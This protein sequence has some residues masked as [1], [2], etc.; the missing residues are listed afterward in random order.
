M[1]LWYAVLILFMLGVNSLYNFAIIVSIH[2][3]STYLIEFEK[4]KTDLKYSFSIYLQEFNT[5]I[6][7][8]LEDMDLIFDS[9]FSA[10]ISLTILRIASDYQ[11]P[12]LCWWDCPLSQNDILFR[13]YANCDEISKKLNS[14]IEFLNWTNSAVFYDDSLC[15]NNMLQNLKYKEKIYA[16]SNM[17]THTSSI[18]SRFVKT[19]GIKTWIL[20]TEADSSAEIQSELIANNMMR[21]GVGILAGPYSSPGVNYDG[22]LKLSYKGQE[23][24]DSKSQLIFQTLKSLLNNVN[25]VMEK[26]KIHDIYSALVSIFHLHIPSDELALFNIQN[27]TIIQIQETKINTTTVYDINAIKWIGG[28]NNPPS[29]SKTKINFSLSAGITNNSITAQ[30]G[31]QIMMNGVYIGAED[32]NN[33]TNRLPGFEFRFQD[34]PCYTSSAKIDTS[35]YDNYSDNFGL[36]HISPHS[37]AYSILLYNYLTQFDLNLFGTSDGLIMEDKNDYPRYISTGI[38]YKYEVNALLQVIKL[39]GFNSIAVVRSNSSSAIEWSNWA[40]EDAKNYKISILNNIS[41]NILNISASGSI[42]NGDSIIENIV[43][44]LSRIVIAAVPE[45]TLL[46]MFSK[47]IDLGLEAG[48][49]YTATKSLKIEI[50]TNI[51]NPNFNKTKD[52]ISGT[53]IIGSA[54]FQGEVG[55]RT[56]KTFMNRFQSYTRRTCDYYDAFMLGAN[57]IEILINS[58]KDYEK[59]TNIMREAR[60]VKF[61]G[62]NG[63]IKVIDYTNLRESEMYIMNQIMYKNN[64]YIIPEVAYYY[65][66]GSTVFQIVEELVWTPSGLP[67]SIRINNWP[68]PFKPSHLKIFNE[69]RTIVWIICSIISL[70]T[71][72]NTIFIWKKFWTN[73]I[74][75]LTEKQEI[76][77][78]DSVLLSTVLIELFQVASMGPDIENL[79]G[80][81]KS[82]TSSVSYNID[83]FVVLTNGIFWYVLLSMMLCSAYWVLLCIVWLFNLHKRFYNFFIFRFLGWSITNIMPIQGNLMFIPIISTLLDVFLC[84]KSLSDSFSDSVLDKDCFQKCWNSKHLSYAIPSG[85]FIFMYQPL[86]VYFRPI[87]QEYLPLLHIKTH[88]KFLM[89]KSVYQILLI[90]LNKTLKRYDDYV[91]SIVFAILIFIYVLVLQYVKAFNYDRLNMWQRIGNIA[92]LWLALICIGLKL[93]TEK[94]YVWIIILLIGLA[95]LIIIGFL[96]QKKKYPSLLYRVEQKSIE[97]IIR[98]MIGSEESKDV[99]KSISYAIDENEIDSNNRFIS[100]SH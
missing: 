37:E 36:F 61:Q 98:W 65:P 34:I 99:F 27:S 76:S 26:N 39:M 25:Q 77:F 40:I 11:I 22:I 29:N 15:S 1:R 73:D 46:E 50:I 100:G 18:I 49:I 10:A 38:P 3:P 97:K 54:F 90:L 59:S 31:N 84:D 96:L 58:G 70:F 23:Y 60:K 24:S 4:L 14:V 62:C 94:V 42:I 80:F 57:A 79:S 64:S 30:I 21:E 41:N 7:R 91:H 44:S 13:I 5:S 16:P 35:C 9:S 55:K 45:T 82:I 52:M 88:P 93:S 53:F 69:G 33:E 72:I 66:T 17:P 78:Q 63:I 87:W 51:S 81:M 83:D 2:T 47:F 48:D 92:V 89:I 8:E 6:S 19:S 20:I 12:Y 74:K 56:E 95:M 71:V 32:I 43:N 85:L 28:S 68:C 67:S 75:T 86:A